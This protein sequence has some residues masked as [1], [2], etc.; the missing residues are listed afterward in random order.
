MISWNEIT[1]RAENEGRTYLMEHEC[2]ELLEKQGI[3]TTGA[4]A[5]RSSAEAVEISN[6]IGYPVVLKVLSPEVIH[7]SDAGG[8]KLN[9]K[10]A[11]E[12]E[13]A[14][15][16]IET[17]FADKKLAGV[18]VQ[19][20]ASPG[21][22]AIIGVSRDPTFG[23]VLMFGLGGVFVEVLKDVSFRILPVTEADIDALIREIRGYTLLRGYRGTSVDLPALKEL[24]LK[25]SE[26]VMRYPGDQGG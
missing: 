7:K 3:P 12:V 21:L 17:A 16:E 18:A 24:L 14:F 11:A 8:V 19:K 1:S 5:A 25:I 20:M 4:S 26:M 22:E 6:R 2:K 15:N 13:R 23:P 10:N 9:L